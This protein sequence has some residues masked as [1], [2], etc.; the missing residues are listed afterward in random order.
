MGKDADL[1]GAAK[2][3]R[4]GIGSLTASLSS[5]PH[6]AGKRVIRRAAIAAAAR[7]Y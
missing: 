5:A 2:E 4:A 1:N 6:L 3:L 7:G